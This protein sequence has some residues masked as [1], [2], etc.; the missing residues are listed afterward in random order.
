M[1]NIYPVPSLTSV[2]IAIW[3]QCKMSL[4]YVSLVIGNE[5]SNSDNRIKTP[6]KKKK[7]SYANIKVKNF[8]KT[9]NYFIII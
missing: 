7:Q 4:A 5:F 8:K 2:S 1:S 9:I 6:P 3:E